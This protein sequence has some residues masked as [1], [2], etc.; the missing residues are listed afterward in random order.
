MKIHKLGWDEY[1]ENEFQPFKESGLVPGR[2]VRETRQI[3]DILTSE[4]KVSAGVAGHFHY[5]A[6]CRADY[7]AAGDWVVLRKS[8]DAYVVEKVLQ[9]K[10]VF[11]R[12][13]AGRETEEQIIAANIDLLCI[14]CGLDGGRNF[15]L[16]GVERYLAMASESGA[17]GLIILNK[18]DL[19]EDREGAILQAESVAGDVPVRM[20]S[21]LTG[22]G[23]E[24]LCENFSPYMTVAFTGPSG[25]GKSALVNALM[26]REIQKT[27]AQR[28]DDKRGRHT[29]T[30]REMFFLPGDVL[31][32]DT[33]GLREL[34]LWGNEETLSDVFPEIAEASVRC[35]FR[36]CTHQG[37]PG[38][39]VQELLMNGELEYERYQNY[40]DMEAEL[41]YLRSRQDEKG[42]REKKAKDRELAKLIR[43]LNKNR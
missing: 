24:S 27:G 3:Y 35:R 28:D 1:F 7:P 23:I 25:V 17:G 38:C 30:R 9:R 16:R 13:A 36:D 15:N 22:E 8:D 18:A 6:A 10:T 12:K 20:V 33:P 21:A 2:V 19:C 26:G 39:A 4:G 32:I 40:L 37:E 5:T 29:T 41:A 31:V 11:S 43:D 14:V 34:Q 42:R